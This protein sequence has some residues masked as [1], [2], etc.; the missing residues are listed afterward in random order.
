MRADA[1]PELRW[2]R[3]GIAAGVLVIG[4]A[5][6]LW[7]NRFHITAPVVFVCLAYLAVIATVYNLWRTGA[8]AVAPENEGADA[9]ARPTGARGELDKEKRTLL[10]A[11]K[12]AEFDQ[13][14]GKLSKK[15]ADEMIANYRARAIEV[16]KELDRLDAGQEGTVKERIRREVKARLELQAKEK[17]QPQRANDRSEKADKAKV[18][19][20]KVEEGKREE[21]KREEG[22][23]EEGKREE[24]KREDGTEPGTGTGTGTGAGAGTGT[25]AGAGTGAATEPGTDAAAAKEAAT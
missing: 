23:R 1:S 12:E 2:I 5:F 15:D 4:W 7:N 17:V 11:I 8:A 10:K 21:G 22:K 13:A 3:R 14:M 20:G 19:P 18:K 16:I 24:G 9:W 25:E 6:V